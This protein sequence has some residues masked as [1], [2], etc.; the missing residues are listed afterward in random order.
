MLQHV[1]NSLLWITSS[2]KNLSFM[3]NN[4]TINGFLRDNNL[5]TLESQV[6]DCN[7]KTFIELQFVNQ[8]ISSE[9]GKILMIT[10]SRNTN[11]LQLSFFSLSHLSNMHNKDM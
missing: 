4:N 9:H 2:P 6:I 3:Y 11:N 8:I 1:S 10:S 5:L 7:I